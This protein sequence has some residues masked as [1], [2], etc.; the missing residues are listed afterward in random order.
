MCAK[1][2]RSLM[3]SRCGRGY[4]LIDHIDANHIL[5]DRGSRPAAMGRETTLE[6]WSPARVERPLSETLLPIRKQHLP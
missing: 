3:N 6:F 2:Q 1:A 5:R 4:P